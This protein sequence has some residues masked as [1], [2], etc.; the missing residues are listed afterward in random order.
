MYRMT[1]YR[2][3]WGYRRGWGHGPHPF[4][5]F[6]L[7]FLFGFVFFGLFRFFLPVIALGLIFMG[8]RALM[9]GGRGGWGRWSE[10]R[11]EFWNRGWDWENRWGGHD[12]WQD[13]RKH[14]W[15]GDEK[16]KRDADSDDQ[17]R[18]TRAPNGEWVE[19]V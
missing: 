18:Y 4:M 10:D 19:I 15:M 1:G 3:D 5:F 12:R 9:H 14:E 8:V 6:P 7:L 13:K 11:R 16:P 17:P 2:G